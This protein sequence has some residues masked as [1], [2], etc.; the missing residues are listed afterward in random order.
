MSLSVRVLE[1]HHYLGRIHEIK[2]P[3]ELEKH[4]VEDFFQNC[5]ALISS[6]EFHEGDMLLINASKMDGISHDGIACLIH[7]SEEVTAK[8]GALAIIPSD[9][10][11]R[12]IDIL[13]ISHFLEVYSSYE[14]AFDSIHWH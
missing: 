3:S 10:V 14:E 11:R 12:V 8:Y 13:F 1:M 6:S 2:S 4:T 9:R 7:I 5:L